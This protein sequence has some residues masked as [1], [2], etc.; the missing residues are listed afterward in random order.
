LRVNL[1]GFQKSGGFL[2]LAAKSQGSST[3]VQLIGG[4]NRASQ[5]ENTPQDHGDEDRCTDC[6]KKAARRSQRAKRGRRSIRNAEG[7]AACW[8]EEDKKYPKQ[9]QQYD[10]AS[11]G[12]HSHRS[13]SHDS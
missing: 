2:N 11:A 5:E 1:V 12:Q 6:G 7:P 13:C 4:F 3:A 10:H 8:K 9:R